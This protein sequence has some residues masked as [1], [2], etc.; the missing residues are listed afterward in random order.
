LGARAEQ[1]GKSSTAFSACVGTADRGSQPAHILIAGASSK[2][3]VLVV[4][5]LS[6]SQRHNTTLKMQN[7]HAMRASFHFK[8]S[9]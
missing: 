2:I 3:D 4:F 1:C 8:H 5:V 7:K 9:T 6:V